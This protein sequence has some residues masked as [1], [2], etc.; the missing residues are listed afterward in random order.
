[1]NG[2][3]PRPSV[4]G[5]A[6]RRVVVGLTGHAGSV[7]TLAWAIAEAETT[8]SHLVV[9][10][11]LGP[12]RGA[13]PPGSLRL[14]Q[15]V[16]RAAA[17]AVAAARQRLGEQAVRVEVC[18]GPAADAL[19][20]AAGPGDLLVLG[21]PPRS[22]WWVRSGTTTRVMA[23]ARCPVTVVPEPRGG[24][25]PRPG[26]PVLVGSAGP[27]AALAYGLAYA[28]EHG[29]PL[30]VGPPERAP[31]EPPSLIVIGAGGTALHPLGVT[32]RSLVAGAG[33]P[34]AV[35]H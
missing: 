12:D 8:G 16:D 17:G 6:P 27:R 7:H 35:V 31:A 18:A 14:L 4:V 13:G 5:Q 11:A 1:M 19:V 9:V 25:L 33:C 2:G 29:L 24:S 22:G 3:A 20:R 34:V 23:L 15:T 10:H 26:G 32:C 21:G 30:V 28:D